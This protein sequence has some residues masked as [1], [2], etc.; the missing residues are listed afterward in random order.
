MLK[1]AFPVDI[2]S[3]KAVYEIQFGTVERPTHTN[4]SWDAEKFETCAQRFADLSEPDYGAAL[5]NDCKYGYDVH[6]GVLRLTLL[7]SPVF[8]NNVDTGFHEFT[9]SFLPHKGTYRQGRVQENACDLNNPLI[10]VA[11]SGSEKKDCR[12]VLVSQSRGIFTETLKPA[13]DGNGYIARVYEGFGCRRKAE[14]FLGHEG[15]V[16]ECTMLEDNLREIEVSGNR[17]EIVFK[18]FEIKT[19]R[20]R[21][22]KY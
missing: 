14:F 15:M 8:P 5:L 10:T 17:F 18:P 22:Q 9:Y 13:E 19:F 12:P 1:T 11:G 2:R 20:I 16:F 3:S 7:R 21:M 6:D 4:T